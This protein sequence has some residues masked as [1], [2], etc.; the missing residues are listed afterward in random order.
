MKKIKYTENN[1]EQLFD[2][3]LLRHYSLDD[4]PK[5][6]AAFREFFETGNIEKFIE[7]GGSAVDPNSIFF[8]GANPT[9]DNLKHRLQLFWDDLLSHPDRYSNS[10]HI[11][12]DLPI[13]QLFQKWADSC[14]SSFEEFFI[15]TELYAE[16]FTW[17][18]GE[19][20]EAER[21][22]SMSFGPENWRPI[23]S[24]NADWLATRLLSTASD[25]FFDM[26][27]EY[28]EDPRVVVPLLGYLCS[29]LQSTSEEI[30]Y[31]KMFELRHRKL[32]G[33]YSGFSS[34]QSVIRGFIARTNGVLLEDEVENGF[35]EIVVSN[36]DHLDA[37][38]KEFEASLPY[39]DL[40]HELTVFV[41]DAGEEYLWASE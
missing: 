22:F 4:K 3:L 28:S 15:P 34:K 27:E 10:I 5:E 14:V 12:K 25:Y 32:D 29:A 38:K 13:A 33:E 2:D 30:Y 7:H 21:L 19:Q 1:R 37:F 16:L 31:K 36:P 9:L 6:F 26:H 11:P 40:Y 8:V 24:C 18:Y 39:P 20:Y 17:I 23:I 41:T 35:E